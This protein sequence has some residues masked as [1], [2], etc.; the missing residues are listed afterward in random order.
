MTPDE[1]AALEEL[2][3][4]MSGPHSNE[5][6]ADRLKCSRQT[7]WRIEQ[8]ALAKMLRVLK[9]EGKESWRGALREPRP[10]PEGRQPRRIRDKSSK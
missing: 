4:E 6:I 2:I 8:E 7:V 3:W 10:T 5:E 1:D 9:R